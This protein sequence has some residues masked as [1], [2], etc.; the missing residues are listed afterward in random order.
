MKKL[1]L[2]SLFIIS[3]YAENENDVNSSLINNITQTKKD[4]EQIK[5]DVGIIKQ[6]LQNYKYTIRR[7]IQKKFIESK[8]FESYEV[9]PYMDN[10]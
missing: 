2:L 1:V 7:E 8:E 9:E 6:E 5:Q 4:V 3:V 10:Y